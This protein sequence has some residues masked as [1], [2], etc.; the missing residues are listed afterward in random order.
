MQR[1]NLIFSGEILPGK[2]PAAVKARFGTLFGIT[3]PNRIEQFFSGKEVVLRRNLTPAQAAEFYARLRGL[4]ALPALAKVVP[5][6][7]SAGEG[8]VRTA[9]RLPDKVA[10]RQA[11]NNR[12]WAPNPYTLR[13]FHDRQAPRR[14][15][16]EAKRL[17]RLGMITAAA[18][19]ALL[20]LGLRQLTL[21]AP[22]PAPQLAAGT[23]HIGGELLLAT[24]Q[25]L[26]RHDR[27]GAERDVTSLEEMGLSGT[28]SALAY[29]A[30]D[31]ILIL[32]AKP[33][34]AGALY[35]CTLSSRLCLPVFDES[36]ATAAT[37][38]A[39][40]A[41]SGN[42]IMADPTNKLLTL[43]G[44]DG[45]L[46]ASAD[47]ELPSRPVLR[48]EGGL[49]LVNGNNTPSISVLRYEPEA[50]AEQL[51]EI[52]L[53]PAEAASAGLSRT[54]DFNW[55]GDHWWVS[56]EN[57]ETGATG[58]FRFDN[59][60]N[61]VAIAPLPRDHSPHQ[62]LSWNQK[63]LV[64][65]PRH[66]Q[67]LRLS[68]NGQVEAPV[69]SEHLQTLVTEHDEERARLAAQSH[70]LLTGLALVLLLALAFAGWQR[71]R[72]HASQGIRYR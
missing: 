8:E 17:C 50:F 1:F 14:R 22:A 35:R 23:S 59:S 5:D 26:L 49:L 63:L 57:P 16:I 9:D 69:L 4:G 65:D 67:L 15:E 18:V 34:A 19:L 58:L 25:L 6:A 42:L 37:A 20:L 56:M 51:D 30:P 52:L 46:L 61:P 32:L 11:A 70:L 60:W 29:S 39:L 54:R 45:Q 41:T 33:P 44:P 38:F 7:I 31:E 62:L 71:L 27:S 55:A 2:A 66:S 28:I 40:V 68:A 3:D 72:L 36:G 21:T 10:T 48:A 64:L 53:L 24:D 13:P 43:H 12:R 47:R